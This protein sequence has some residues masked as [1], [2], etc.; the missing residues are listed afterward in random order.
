[1]PK[2]SHL[3][4]AAASGA[5]AHHFLYAKVMAA[6]R[7]AK[8]KVTL[9]Y[10]S[11]NGLGEPIRLTL[12]QAGVPFEDHR[13]ASRDEFTALKPSLNFGQVPALI[14]NGTEFVQSAATMRYIATTLDRSGGL[15]PA[16]PV[17]RQRLDALMDQ[18]KD[19]MTGRLVMKYKGRF[20]FSPE[21]VTEEVFQTVQ[22]DWFTTTLP[23]HFA[24]FE[25]Q[26]RASKTPY[27]A[28]APSVTI[29]DIFVATHMKAFI[30]QDCDT[31]Q[32]CQCEMPT[33][34]ACHFD[35]VFALPA[36]SAFKAA[37][38]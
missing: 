16:D 34:I 31:M 26:L 18:V 3:A 27:F 7:R 24:F 13:F 11:I 6:I 33:S 15:Y 28:D 22:K 23:R 29:A 30:L 9:K 4:L 8:A 20:G 36:I 19:M 37:E 35:R 2:L 32:A 10:F 25:A 14:V 21:V 17:M 5:L 12:A 38:K 1:M